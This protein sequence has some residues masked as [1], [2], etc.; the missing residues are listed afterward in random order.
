MQYLE[1]PK[2]APR[3]LKT[4]T[5]TRARLEMLAF[6]KLDPRRRAQTSP[7]I[8]EMP[9][10]NPQLVK[11]L[12]EMSGGRCAFCEA[13]GGL[14]VHRFRP[15]AN[16]LPLQ[17][18][19]NA[20]LYY[21]WLADAWQN[22]YPICKTCIPPEPQ[23]PVVGPRAR[24]PAAQQIE[25][26]VRSGDGLWPSYPPKED[27]LLLDPARERDF[28]KHLL[29]K[30]DGELIGESRRG[31]TTILVFNLNRPERRNQRYQVFQSR[32]ELLRKIFETSPNHPEQAEFHRF[33]EFS[34]LEFG[35]S[36]YLML[37]RIAR[38]IAGA[39]GIGWRTSR[40]AILSFYT[41]LAAETDAADRVEAAIAALIREDAGLR[42]GRFSAGVYSLRVPIASVEIRNFKAIEHF[43][44]EFTLP[45]P[46]SA[47]V[48]S[49]R[50][51]SLVI[52][53]ENAT[54]K[55]SIL[56]AIAL[57]LATPQ[58]RSALGLRWS[59][60]VLDPSQLGVERTRAQRRASVGLTLANGQSVTLAIEQGSASAR[61][62]FGNHQVPVFAYGAYRRFL[63][64]TRRP[65][66]HKH[67]RNLFDGSTLSNPEPW[68]KSLTQDRFDLVIRT[69]RDLL[70]IEGEFDVIQRERS[71]RQLRMVTSLVEPDG[72]TRY[73]RTP[74][75]AVSS[76]YRSM[77][78]ML[79]D[80]MRGLLDPQVYEGFESFQT[81]Q[82]IVLI[83]EIEAHLHPRWKMRIM[84]SLRAALPGMS[85]IVTTHDPLCLRG[86]GEGEVVVLQR[87][88]AAD[89]GQASQLPILV[90]RMTDLPPVADLRVEQL[91]TSDFFQLL[92]SDDASAD[93]RLA[94]IGDL[95]AQRERGEALQ[96]ADQDVLAGFEQD[97]AAA[98][99]VGSSE[100]HRIVQAAVAEY[101]EQ[102]REA[103]SDTLKRLRK[104]A[105]DEVLAALQRL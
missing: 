23:F 70:S 60:F 47:D 13:E 50:A 43:D 31:E 87:V 79:C 33:F 42:A 73:T 93:R 67:I 61:S 26:Y 85:F 105:K 36:W 64:G 17:P 19:S 38:W 30:L 15:A 3:V 34:D 89:S 83:D 8:N 10:D 6:W 63:A 53:G 29:P 88:A 18:S 25:N 81:A 62:E 24:L 46:V 104:K 65:A 84:S 102:R 78:A 14:H 98:L 74:L 56:E 91:L 39:S 48:A 20:H 103:S 27:S 68:L 75:Q 37:R 99:P 97:V 59:R 11:A 45:P 7:P 55:S 76:G 44:L 57:A 80:I 32:I 9:L 92:S 90:E 1:R 54:G 2:A 22:L 72:E 94:K 12:W 5:A 4:A 41:R 49:P 52:L 16:A 71:T 86:M 28:E 51:P 95:I 96:P 66:P 58:A 21:V 77:L 82:G 100:V 40:N 101:L 69:L 35:G